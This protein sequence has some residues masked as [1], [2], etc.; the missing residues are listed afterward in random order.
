MPQFLKPE[1]YTR[2]LALYIF[3]MM[4]ESPAYRE[5]TPYHR[6]GQQEKLRSCL[7]IYVQSSPQVTCEG[8]KTQM[9]DQALERGFT[10]SAPAKGEEVLAANLGLG[11]ATFFK[12]RPIGRFS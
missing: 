2:V 12:Q 9:I 7:K 8:L 1:H 5:L 3:Q 4:F 6:E 11:Q 10:F